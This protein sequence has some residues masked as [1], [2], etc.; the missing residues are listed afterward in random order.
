MESAH[1]GLE[2]VLQSSKNLGDLTQAWIREII[3]R[4]KA[5]GVTSTVKLTVA[6]TVSLVA[7]AALIA[8]VIQKTGMASAPG[9]IRV[10]LIG[11]DPMI[12]LDHAVWASLAG[13]MI[14]RPGEVEIILTYAEQAITSLY[15]IAQALRLPHCTV[16]TPEQIQG[17]SAACVSVGL[18]LHPAAEVDTEVEQEHLRIAQQLMTAAVPVVACVFNE[19][20]LNGQNIVL[21]QAKLRLNP[22]GDVI[23]RGSSAINRFGIFSADLG[24]E[25]GWGAIICRLC[26][27]SGER[28]TDVDVSQV[29]TALAVLRLEGGLSSTWSLGQRVNGVAFNRIIPVGLMGNLAIEPTTGQLLSNDEDTNRLAIVGN[30]WAEKLKTMPSGGED[31]LV[32]A[33]SVKLSY[34]LAFPKEP[35]KRD[36]TIA[37]LEQALKEGVLDAGI[38]LARGYEATGKP[39]LREKALQIYRQIGSAHPLSAYA[40]AHDELSAGN[41]KAA[42]EHF[43]A[44]A[45]AGYPLALT[46]LAVFVLQHQL[47][48]IDPWDLL[49]RSAALGDP[50]ANVYLAER[51]M[52][53]NLPQEALDLLRKAWQVGHKGAV[54]LAFSLATYMRDQKLGNRHKLKQE[55]RDIEGQAKKLGIKFA[56]GGN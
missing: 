4:A 27:A 38:A 55:L 7:P 48:G 20:D 1:V 8:S 2:N 42:L 56:H 28:H 29:K 44:S 26:P 51:R 52:N 14:G 39:E 46:D 11:R 43:K 16:M 31:L 35:E 36:A 37:A 49:T 50:D 54:D 25:G 17:G 18:W 15:P 22:L 9:P 3:A 6:D 5:A 53:E 19:T 41:D 23:R 33:S 12:R 13:D 10:L 30:L 24:L 45:E 34:S 47:E 32:W 21:S 40:L